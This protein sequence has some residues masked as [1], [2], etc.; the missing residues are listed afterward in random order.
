MVPTLSQIVAYDPQHLVSAS[1]HWDETAQRWE[2][3]LGEF[4]ASAQGLDFHGKTAG[5]VRDSA[6][7]Q[8]QGAVTDADKLRQAASV[9]SNAAD[10]L[11]QAKQRVL[12]VAEHAVNN[13]FSVSDTYQVVDLSGSHNADSAARQAAAQEMSA[14]MTRYAG[15]LYTHDADTAG[16]M[17]QAVDFKTD[18][19][20]DSQQCRDAVKQAEQDREH[21]IEWAAGIGLAG[22]AIAGP[23]TALAGAFGMGA[24]GALW[25]QYTHKALPGPCQ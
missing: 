19:G 10:E 15:E 3:T 8:H 11:R 21:Q 5:A 7:R 23:E 14:D 6:A 2:D 4:H 12:R 16:R 13:G 20:L 18:G 24:L 1:A 17:V 25:Y 22:G 9:A